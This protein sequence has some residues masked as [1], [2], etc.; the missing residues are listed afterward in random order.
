M[1]VFAAIAATP[2]KKGGLTMEDEKIIFY[3]GKAFLEISEGD[4][5]YLGDQAFIE[6]LDKVEIRS[7]V[8]ATMLK[9]KNGT[10]RVGDT[11]YSISTTVH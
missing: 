6:S 7:L 8:R 2:I 9:V 3:D 10:R 4:W 5:L 1:F 11:I